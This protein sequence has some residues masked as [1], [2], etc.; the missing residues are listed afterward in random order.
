MFDPTPYRPLFPVT[1]QYTYLNHASV[2]GL[3]VPSVQAL[4]AYMAASS[5]QAVYSEAAWWPQVETARAKLARLIGAG[6]DEIA[7]VL[8]DS[9]GLISVANGLPWVP[10]DNVV[11]TAE[12]FPANLYPW[13]NLKADGVEVRLVPRHEGRVLL[14]DIAAAMDS[15]TRIVTVSW[16]EF[17]SGFRQDLRALADLVHSRGALLCVD[18]IQ[19]LG[20]LVLDVA[21]AGVD[22]VAGGAHKWLLGP[23]GVGFLY[24]RADRLEG[25]RPRLASWR[26]VP[27]AMDFTAL[28]QPWLASARRFE[29]GTPN[30]LGL[31]AFEAVLDLMLEIGPPVIEGHILALTDHLIAR[32][33]DGGYPVASPREPGTRSGIVCFRPKGEDPE[34]VVARL[35]AQQISAAARSGI[36]RIS[37]H[38]YNTFA[39][40]DRL[41]APGVL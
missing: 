31:I 29:G 36:V 1:E 28:D 24:V 41:F 12:Q 18:V 33:D 34:T 37:P 17:N 13:F 3:C 4:Q 35:A 23:P 19:G 39:E 26:S 2:A 21:A 5:H 6:P 32:L 38:F 16:V 15:R 9:T 8:N 40:I 20:G 7:W 25:L 14:E 11:T 27:N 10:G 30:L 22:F